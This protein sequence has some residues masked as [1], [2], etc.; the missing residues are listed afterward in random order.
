MKN[1][2][3]IMLAGVIL[4]LSIPYINAQEKSVLIKGSF[5][6]IDVEITTISPTYEVV[7]QAYKNKNSEE[8]EFLVLLKK[9]IDKWLKDGYTLS[10]VGVSSYSASIYTMVYVLTKK[11]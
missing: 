9:E 10:E 2:K 3:L 7:K 11:E 1:L 8:N 6:G 4:F 5:T